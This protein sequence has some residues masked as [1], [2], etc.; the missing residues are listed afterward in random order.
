MGGVPG[1]GNLCPLGKRMSLGVMATLE[2]EE[3]VGRV[4]A[5]ATVVLFLN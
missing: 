2:S 3:R 1:K 5:A 4:K